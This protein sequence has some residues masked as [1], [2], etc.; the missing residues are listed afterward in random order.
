M[1]ASTGKLDT[2]KLLHK[3]KIDLNAQDIVIFSRKLLQVH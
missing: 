1:A 2:I 3:Y